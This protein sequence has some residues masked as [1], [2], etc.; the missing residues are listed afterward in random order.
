M[1][2][3]FFQNSIVFSDFL[4]KFKFRI[5]ENEIKIEPRVANEIL[6]TS[7]YYFFESDWIF[8]TNFS[9]NKIERSGFL[10]LRFICVIE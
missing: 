5:F 2:G 6:T 9:E 4:I 8:W 7:S 10:A 1:S 3:F